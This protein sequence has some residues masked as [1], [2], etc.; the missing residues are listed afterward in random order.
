M[1][2]KE[3]LRALVA[4]LE[5]YQKVSKPYFYADVL[6]TAALAWAPLYAVSVR[7]LDIWTPIFLLVAYL[8]F[9][10]GTAFIH[11]VIHFGKK[12]K[13]ITLFYNFLF[14]FPNRIPSYIHEPHKFHHLP[15][16]FGT[17]RDPEYLYLKGMGGGYF[18]RPL[19]AGLLAP[20][21]LVYRFGILPM[22]YWAFTEEKRMNLF[23]RMSTIVVNPAYERAEWREADLRRAYRQDAGCVIFLWLLIG[24]WVVGLLPTAF[25]GWWYLIGA[26]AT[27]VN[28]YRARVAHRYDNREGI[29]SPL[30][31]LRDST[32]IEGGI[33]SE[34][35]APIGLKYHALHHLAPQIPYHNLG[36]A[37][38][39][40]RA[41]LAPDHPYSRTVLSTFW[42][43]IKQYREVL[44]G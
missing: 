39:H 32:T 4:S 16:T 27:A 40:L 18:Y 8:A 28:M 9:Y 10:R 11:E 29:L 35:W 44:S 31:A 26:V 13:G 7:D 43:G 2:E 36:K 42:Q 5:P 22:V 1:R 15:N 41:R 17:E 25:F 12:V 38:R 37:H 21:V 33:A 3:E 14:G 20:F 23:R 6:L 19:Y 34:L 30:A 24:A